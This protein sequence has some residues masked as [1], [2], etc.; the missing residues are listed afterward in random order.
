MLMESECSRCGTDTGSK[1]SLESS[2]KVEVAAEIAVVTEGENE[3]NPRVEIE[4]PKC[5]HKEAFFW[6]KQTRSSDEAETRFYKCTSCKYT[7]RIY[8]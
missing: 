3:I 8:R 2:E 7:W 4:C 5:S 6:S 1:V